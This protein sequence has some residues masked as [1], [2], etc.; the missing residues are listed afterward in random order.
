MISKQKTRFSMF[1]RI[2]LFTAFLGIIF[3]FSSC[4]VDYGLDTN[5]YDVV[6]SYYDTTYIWGTANKYSLIDSVVQLGDGS[7]THDYDGLIK[8]SVIDNMTRM[9]WTRVYDST[10]N[11]VIALGVTTTTT[12]VYG[13]GWYDY[14]GWYGGWYYWDNNNYYYD[15]SWYYPY[16]P[17]TSYSYTTGTVMM[18]MI[19][20]ALKN[21]TNKTLPVEWIGI[22]NGVANASSTSSRIT[23]GI[24][25]AFT[26][27]P[28][29]QVK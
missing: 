5:N 14:Y 29:L 23:S 24:N 1:R 13:S 22:I 20:P 17:T 21:T 26:Q 2:V 11:V 27:S 10:A 25:Q 4:F 8:Q 28:Y 12:Y 7:I 16:Y 9:G 6:A 19:A 18:S 3:T 15:Y